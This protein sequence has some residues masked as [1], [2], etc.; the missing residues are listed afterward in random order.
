MAFRSVSP[1]RMRV[2]GFVSQSMTTIVSTPS[3]F[4]VA[5]VNKM[6]TWQLTGILLQGYGNT[7]PATSDGRLLV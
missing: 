7:A 2:L 6:W 4:C 1:I 5:G 3:A